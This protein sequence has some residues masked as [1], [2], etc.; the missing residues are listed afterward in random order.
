MTTHSI[1]TT[2]L[3]HSTFKIEINGKTILIDPWVTGNPA[4]PASQKKFK[5]V[6]LMLCTHG[7]QDHIGDAVPIVREHQPK[8]IGIFELC[9]WLAK[10]GAKNISPMNKGGSQTVDGIK[11]TMVHADHSC[12]IQDDDGSIIYGG[13][14]VGYVLK[15]PNGTTLYR[16]GDTNVFGDMA[17]IRE[18]YAPDYAMLPIGDLFTMSPVEV[19]YACHLLRPK[20]VIPMHFGTFPPL[21]GRPKQLEK[22]SRDL[23]IEVW[24][25]KPG[26]SR[27]LK[28][29]EPAVVK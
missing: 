19:A 17:I 21:T 6:D 24:E 12:G 25:M 11:I 13:E 22:M 5:K 8:V 18:L 23:D 10:K 27:E 15:F 3:G 14:A 28:V 7:H 20:V 16:A 29:L 9:Q 26:E 2:W 4:C 1:H